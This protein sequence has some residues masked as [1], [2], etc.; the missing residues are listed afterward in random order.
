MSIRLFSFLLIF[1]SFVLTAC[2]AMPKKTAALAD[3][4]LPLPEELLFHDPGDALLQ[5]AIGSYIQAQS[6]PASSRYQFS[7]IDLN[8]DG[9]REGIVIIDTPYHVWCNFDGCRM[10]V[11]AAGNDGFAP[12]AEIAPVRGPLIV[13]EEKTNGWRD[14]LVR[15]SGRPGWDAKTVALQFDGHTYPAHPDYQPALKVADNQLAGTRIFP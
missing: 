12:V 4:L 9:R 7:R 14:L 11:F 1:L 8:G 5:A 15:V 3:P 6:G 2:S 13:S 10:A